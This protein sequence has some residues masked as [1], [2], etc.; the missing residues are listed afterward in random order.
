MPLKGPHPMNSPTPMGN[1][2]SRS[3]MIEDLWENQR[4]KSNL[5]LLGRHAPNL[6]R[7]NDPLL[8]KFLS[9]TADPELALEQL[10]RW[11]TSNLKSPDPIPLATLWEPKARPLDCA[12]RVLGS[13]K[14]FGDHLARHPSAMEVCI[15]PVKRSPSLWEMVEHLGRELVDVNDEPGQ[16]RIL[17]R[18]RMAQLLRV[19]INDLYRERPLE[20]ITRDISR[21]ADAALEVA[22][23]IAH[24]RIAGRFGKPQTPDGTE[25]TCAL[26]AMGKLGGEELNYSSDIDVLLVYSAEGQTIGGKTQITASEFH[27]RLVSEVI[28][29]LSAH[30]EEGMG[31]RID[32]R[33]RPEGA[34][35]PLA[36]ALAPTLAYYDNHGRTW[37][38]QALIKVRTVA[39]NALLGR[40]FRR[41]VQD[42]IYRKYLSFSEIS[43]IKALK[44]RIERR[45]VAGT[46]GIDIKTGRG[47][48]RDIEYTIQFLQL[49]NGGDLPDIRQKNTLL[50]MAALERHGCLTDQESRVL[51]DS[52]RF[53]R[54]VE[55]KLQLVSDL[56]TH[57]IPDSDNG[58]LRLARRM[59]YTDPAIGD[60]WSA[61][62]ERLRSRTE[63]TYTILNHLVHQA[64]P[65]EKDAA[66]IETDILLD[67]DPEPTAVREVL[68]RHRFSD[69][70]S[71]HKNLLRLAAEPSP[72]LSSRRT[73]HFFSSIAPAI[74]RLASQ[75]ADPDRTISQLERITASLGGKSGLWE[76]FNFHEPSL[77]LMINICTG[78]KMLGDLLMDNPGMIDELVDALLLGKSQSA[79]GLAMELESLLRG[80]EDPDLILRSF[81][82]KELLG[83][84]IR[85]MTGSVGINA[86]NQA[87]TDLAEVILLA[88]ASNN[89][90]MLEREKG[91][92]LITPDRR[93]QHALVA[94]GRLGAGQM[95][96]FSD[97]DLIWIYEDSENPAFG[98]YDPHQWHTSL[99]QGLV[100]ASAKAGGT[101]P[102]FEIDLRL[103]PTGRSGSL[104]LPLGEFIR[105]HK[106]GGG[107][108]LWERLAL[109][110][111]RILGEKSN[112]S[113][114]VQSAINDVI[115]G[116]PWQSA[117]VA[118]AALMRSRLEA[119]RPFQPSGSTGSGRDLKRAPGGMVDVE[120]I[121]ELMQLCHAANIPEILQPN[122][123]QSLN[124]LAETGCLPRDRAT[125][126]LN[127]YSHLCIVQNR[128]RI[129]FNRAI[130]TLPDSPAALGILAS[131]TGFPSGAALQ[132]SV[133][134]AMSSIRSAYLETM[135][136][137]ALLVK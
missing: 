43:E 68:T 48:I 133:Y 20:E 2:H 124:M 130:D 101:R 13:G 110:R 37:E 100:R 36:M 23:D 95:S 88:M 22:L 111:S 131:Q 75:S 53:L 4:V 102:L 122:T 66:E 107:G 35:G 127:D 9:K 99:A 6:I 109:T 45:S 113:T 40:L 27:A 63:P 103:R 93:C 58:R 50:A 33:L 126:I 76:L 8:G 25:I 46:G 112:F 83:I 1:R 114:L 84:G 123:F 62:Q 78:G 125:R 5:A 89:R 67:P 26:L 90:M 137:L 85:E 30:S 106:E 108:R 49:L 59:G 128:V 72:F 21:I 120:F 15:H 57:R 60:P 28:R 10:A 65:G 91:P 118:E 119:S 81:R 44:R 11:Q 129:H 136:E 135:R 116:H 54:N 134:G 34:S 115:S 3:G 55:H 19:A 42:F 16:I 73:R 117:W 82:D 121:V 79:Q 86:T 104:A 61:F 64:F 14:I 31:W 38:R 80:A 41:G 12:L 56:Q 74:L 97:L 77:K 7:E 96:Y 71:A 105:Y 39:G 70:V 47:G 32:L 18:F 24:S 69:P 29:L 98:D 92:P 52:Y 94:L 51:D 87:I 17:R 132:A